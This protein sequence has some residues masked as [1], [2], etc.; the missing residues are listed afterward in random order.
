MDQSAGTSG[1]QSI[2]QLLTNRE[3]QRPLLL[4]NFL[5]KSNK[6]ENGRSWNCIDWKLEDWS[7]SLKNDPMKIRLGKLES[8]SGEPQWESTCSISYLKFDDLVKWSYGERSCTTTSG[9][10]I[11]SET[12]WAYYDYI[13]MSS[14][15]NVDFLKQQVSWDSF[16][17]A[18]RNADKSSLWI[19]TTG[20]HTPCHIDTYG[21]NLVAQVY[22]KKRWLLFPPDQTK[23]LYPTRVPY[24]ES[25]I[26]SQVDFTNIDISKYPSLLKTT[27]YSVTLEAGDALFVP[28]HWWHFVENI[29]FAISI[30]TWIE[31]PSDNEDRLKESLVQYQISNVCQGAEFAEEITSLLN[32]NMIEIAAMGSVEINQN[33]LKRLGT[34]IKSLNST[35]NC[36]NGKKDV[37]SH[38]QEPQAK[39]IKLSDEEDRFKH[40]GITEV[41]EKSFQQHFG[42]TNSLRTNN[43]SSADHRTEKSPDEKLRHVL[44]ESLTD[45]RVIDL[46][47]LVVK[48]KIEMYKD[49][50][51]ET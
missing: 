18:G 27:P 36:D 19:G 43:N 35:N 21:C 23:D 9:E 3:P 25:S 47:T 22:G 24:E 7:N 14:L 34:F 38:D 49:S 41:T 13:Y 11:T 17:F 51:N 45:P 15:N 32:P 44:A 16:G 50:V 6:N 30:N 28:N 12:H 48:E 37:K 39:K 20:A 46:L 26:Y 1:S 33:I 10:E 4:K 29:S 40:F 8:N 2:Y 31:L 5:R 42:S